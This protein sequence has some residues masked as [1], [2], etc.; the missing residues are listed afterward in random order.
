MLS[1]CDFDPTN[2]FPRHL[3]WLFGKSGISGCRNLDLSTARR[4]LLDAFAPFVWD[5]DTHHNAF[6]AYCAVWN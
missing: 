5:L 2:A 6:V 3:R 4:A 1:S